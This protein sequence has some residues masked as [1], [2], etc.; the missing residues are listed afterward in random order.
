MGRHG[1]E[2]VFAL[3][4]QP[5]RVRIWLLLKISPIINLPLING[6]AKGPSQTGISMKKHPLDL[7]NPFVNIVYKL[8][9][10]CN[11]SK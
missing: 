4:T 7:R 8:L 11:S 10:N 9:F 1:T 6:V 3:S 2:V 5:L